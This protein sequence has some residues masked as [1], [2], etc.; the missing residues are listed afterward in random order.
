M[1]LSARETDILH[2]NRIYVSQHMFRQCFEPY[3]PG[4]TME[5]F[6][7]SD[8]LLN[9]FHVLLEG[10][11]KYLEERN[12]NRLV[13]ALL[14]SW[15]ALG[16]SRVARILLGVALQLMGQQ[17]DLGPVRNEVEQ[18]VERVMQAEEC[19]LPDWLAPASSDLLA[20]DYK[21]FTVRGFYTGSPRLRCYF[22]AFA[23]LKSIPLRL[24]RVEELEAAWQLA[25]AEVQVNDKWALIRDSYKSMA[26]LGDW[27]LG[28][29]SG[30][31]SLPEFRDKAL[32]LP[33]LVLNDQ[34]SLDQLTNLRVL[35]GQALPDSIFF[36]Q[37]NPEALPEP[38]A[39]C[40]AL[41]S[42][43]FDE[44]P[45]IA[46]DNEHILADYLQV[47]GKLLEP[48]PPEA[49]DFMQGVTWQRK[50]AN[51]ML[52]A[53]AQMRH[54]WALQAK[55]I[56][57][58][59]G[60]SEH[61]KPVGFVEPVP[62][63]YRRM[64]ALVERFID[65]LNKVGILEPD[66][67]ELARCLRL[68][69]ERLFAKAR[70]VPGDDPHADINRKHFDKGA[71]A[72]LAE[73]D[74]LEKGDDR[75]LLSAQMIA[76]DPQ[77]KRRWHSLHAICMGLT[78][79]ADKQLK[80]EHHNDT[81]RGFMLGYG[82]DLADLMFYEGDTADEPDDDAPR[83]CEIGVDPRTNQRLQVGV[84]RPQAIFVLYPTPN[85]PLLCRGAVLPYGQ[86]LSDR[87]LTNDEW[88]QLSPVPRPE[89]LRD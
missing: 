31:E 70:E 43:L 45:V 41:G 29:F 23:W 15:A 48:P 79:L 52:A 24:G 9:G 14:G 16:D 59:A 54:T 1:E 80:G 57:C 72:M 84:G 81:D 7:T 38:E 20:V 3:M 18:E 40:A 11:V 63:F 76:G 87:P 5:R 49:P 2:R 4:V 89:Y 10:T 74:A 44:R 73:A 62:D 69:A 75:P 65:F 12:A 27:D 61:P 83:V 46:L 67:V 28:V 78:K 66:R 64:V 82:K 6:I 51:T 37:R 60:F 34:L 13:E 68:D 77:L 53:W 56:W 22:R 55:E 19:L 33:P 35:A 50:S 39:L 86:C 42:S 36:H 85:G 88:K 8:S 21:R 58:Y 32:K 25:R 26:A 47:V 71:R 30:Q 17:V